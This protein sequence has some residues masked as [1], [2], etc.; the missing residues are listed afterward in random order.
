MSLFHLAKV[1]LAPLPI[2]TT[3]HLVPLRLHFSSQDVQFVQILRC[4]ILQVVT[5]KLSLR[6]PA[7]L[8]N[9]NKLVTTLLCYSF[10]T[11]DLCSTLCPLLHVSFYF[12]LT[13]I[14]DRKCLLSGSLLSGHHGYPDTHFFLETTRMMS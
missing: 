12:N 13:E 3:V 7:G 4:A 6:F 10:R 14:S 9:T 2:T 11:L 5:C 8:A 1:G